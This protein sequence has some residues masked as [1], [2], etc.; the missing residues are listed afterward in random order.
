MPFKSILLLFILIASKQSHAQLCTG[1][2]GEP[3][4]NITFGNGTTN[5]VPLKNGVTNLKYVSTDCPTDGEYTLTNITTNCFGASWHSTSEDH[6]KDIKGRFM[7]INARN[8]PDDFYIETIP[9]LCRNTTYEFGAW[10]ANV[11]KKTSCGG[12]GTKPNLTFSI[13]TTTGE[14]LGT[15]NTQEIPEEE[16][17]TWKQYGFQFKPDINTTSIVLRI[18]N[19]AGVGCG[20]DL[21]IDDITF[22]PCGPNIITEVQNNNTSSL[23]ICKSDLQPMQFNS[24]VGNGFLNPFFQWQSSLNKGKTWN[25]ISAANTTD[26]LWQP[27]VAG[28]FMHRMQVGELANLANTECRVSSPVITVNLLPSNPPLNI[29]QCRGGLVEFTAASGSDPTVK[30]SWEGPNNFHSTLQNPS[31]KSVHLSQAGSYKVTIE[32]SENCSTFNSVGL[33]VYNAINGKLTGESLICWGES[34]QLMASGASQYT[35]APST[36]LSDSHSATV[37]ASPTD[38]TQYHVLIADGTGCSDSIAITINVVKPPILSAG[39]DQ[40]IFEGNTINL[41]GKL[42]GQYLSYKWTPNSF[43]LN[44]NSLSP[45]VTPIK[46]IDY[47]LSAIALNSCGE[48]KDTVN[49]LVYIN[50]KAP[51]VFSPN[52]DGINDLWIIPGLEAYPKASLSVF[53]RLGQMVYQSKPYTG[54]W[55]GLYKGIPLPIGTYYYIIERGLNLEILSGSIQ[56]IR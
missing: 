20:N 44:A 40:R 14:I 28:S 15:Y 26:Y 55:N 23:N 2:L 4:V 38:T 12:N 17:L 5:A 35:W 29:V 47:E 48:V 27:T 53:N 56:I 41:S 21:A 7:L 37:I 10:V 51:N 13:E 6:S 36:G 52:G 8:T 1:S 43:M 30:Y 19:N 34:T 25:N 46:T 9:G 42:S 54:S 49:I 45:S 16:Q 3:V 11:L 50:T 24:S 18:R 39:L 22:R 32:S 33:E 31:I